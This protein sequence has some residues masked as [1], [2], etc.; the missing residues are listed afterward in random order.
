[1]LRTR[2]HGDVTEIRL[3]TTFLGRRLYSVS[4]YLFD[5]ALID[6]GPPRT[7]RELAA[8]AEGQPIAQIVNTHHHEDHVGGN[9]YLAH[10]PALA[11][12]ETVPRLARAPRIPLFRRTTFGQPRPAV[13][14][15]LGDT[16]VTGRHTLRVIPTPGHAFDHVVLWLPE[17]GWLFS[18]DLYLMER[19]RCV[20]R[21]DDL[22]LWMDSLRRMLGYD[23][24][25]MFCAH[26]G[27]VPDAH[28]AIRRKLAY[29]EELRAEARELSEKGCRAG[30]I[31]SRLLGREGFLTYWSGGTFSKANLV[32]A[33]LAIRD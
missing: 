29:W 1:M 8:W 7:G 11:P 15:T 25:T 17:R 22:G 24:D 2:Q 33:L 6:T 23:F 9:A 3:T 28:A 27:R 21:R 31:R 19:A 10:L 30:A 18:A 14:A 26:A 20:R 4:A 16:V 5:G 13:A 12:P 32:N